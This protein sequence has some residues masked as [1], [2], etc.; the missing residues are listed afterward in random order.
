M[1]T[2]AFNKKK[3]FM[4]LKKSK[5]GHVRTCKEDREM[6]SDTIMLLSQKM[7]E[8]D[9]LTCVTAWI[10]AGV[11]MNKMAQIQRIYKNLFT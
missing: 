10:I 7:K 4:D 5:E 3:A 1:Y 9:I 2:Y 6:G 11:I 8:N